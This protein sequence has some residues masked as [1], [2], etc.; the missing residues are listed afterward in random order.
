MTEIDNDHCRNEYNT[1]DI[2]SVKRKNRINNRNK[3]DCD[4]SL[5]NNNNCSDDK[6]IN[7]ND[8]NSDS[9]TQNSSIDEDTVYEINELDRNKHKLIVLADVEICN[10]K[11]KSGAL[12]ENSKNCDKNDTSSIDDTDSSASVSASD[13]VYVE[14]S[15]DTVNFQPKPIL[16]NGTSSA[17]ASSAAPKSSSTTK[18]SVSFD[19]NDDSVKKF[20]SGDVIVDQENPFKRANALKRAEF[21]SY[22]TANGVPSFPKPL[23]PVDKEEFVSTEDVLKE[24]KFVRTYIKHPDEYFVYDP[25]LKQRLLQEEALERAAR[26]RES[27][28]SPPKKSSRISRLTHERLK[29]LK[30]KYSPPPL[31]GQNKIRNGNASKLLNGSVSGA[32]FRITK[33]NKKKL[34]DR[35]KYPELSQI[36]VKI[37]TDLEESLFNPKEVALNARKFDVRIKNTQFGSQDDLDEITDI[38]SAINGDALE[39]LELDESDGKVIEVRKLNCI[40]TTYNST[41]QPSDDKTTNS[42]TNT[43]NSKEFQEYLKGKG[44]S[45]LPEQ[46]S[47][48]NSNL[49]SNGYL[50]TP[51]RIIEPYDLSCVM[52]NKKPKKPSVLQRLFPSGIFSSR[53]KTTP[54]EITPEPRKLGNSSDASNVGTKRLVLQRPSGTISL[55]AGAVDRIVKPIISDDRS[56]SISSAL[57]NAE[58][59]DYS[60]YNSTPKPKPLERK[61]QYSEGK[62]TWRLAN[63][64]NIRCD[65]GI[66]YI[67]SSSNST[68]V[69]NENLGGQVKLK[70]V[71]KAR[72]HSGR[73][74]V[75]IVSLSERMDKIRLS[76]NSVTPQPRFRKEQPIAFENKSP[77]ARDGIVKPKV[78][79]PQIPISNLKSLPGRIIDGQEKSDSL[80]KISKKVMENGNVYGQVSSRSSS[81]ERGDVKRRNIPK[82]PERTTKSLNTRDVVD[83]GRQSG[84]PQRTTQNRNSVKTPDNLIDASGPKSTSTPIVEGAQPQFVVANNK[85]GGDFYF[86]EKTLNLSPIPCL[87]QTNNQKKVE[88]DAYSWAKLRELKE[89]TDRQLYARPLVVYTEQPYTQTV[90]SQNVYGRP[91]ENRHINIYEPLPLQNGAN[92]Q[93]LYAK[94]EKKIPVLQKNQTNLIRNSP[95]RQSLDSSKLQQRFTN[96]QTNYQQPSP[97]H[98]Q[99]LFIRN[100]PQRNTVNGPFRGIDQNGLNPQYVQSQQT[101]PVRIPI[102][103]NLLIQQQPPRC[104]SVLDEMITGNTYG[105]ANSRSHQYPPNVVRR[106]KPS[107]PLTREEIMNQ[108][109]EFC[110][111]S[112]NKTPTKHFQNSTDQ[113]TVIHKDIVSKSSSEISPISYASMDSKT[114]PSIASSRSSAKIAPQ[115]P[116]RIQS[117]RPQQRSSETPIYEAILKRNSMQSCNSDVF[118]SPTIMN[119]HVTF[120]RRNLH[121][122]ASSETDSAIVSDENTPNTC[123]YQVPRNFIVMSSEQVT[124]THVL[125]Y[126]MPA[127]QVSNKQSEPIYAIRQPMQH[128]RGRQ[129]TPVYAQ[130]NGTYAYVRLPNGNNGT[131]MG[132]SQIYYP[133]HVM[134]KSQV[135]PTHRVHVTADGRSTPLILHAMPSPRVSSTSSNSA[136][137]QNPSQLNQQPIKT[138]LT[139]NFDSNN[140]GR[141][142]VLDNVEQ[143]YRPIIINNNTNNNSSNNE[144]NQNHQHPQQTAN[145]KQINYV[146]SGNQIVPYEC[147]STSDAE[148]LQNILY[149]GKRQHNQNM[150][151]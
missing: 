7:V 71:P 42:F 18:K 36:K 94:V 80:K 21:F 134:A 109:T 61:H 72:Q 147:E 51:L 48:K 29:E 149:N 133:N 66:R 79:R 122:R 124:P 98:Q 41:P 56:S 54:K 14:L 2:D 52:E 144:T 131:P 143:L 136:V 115:V 19:T 45:L 127:I 65:S 27:R 151:E 74:S 100:S 34:L 112:M 11:N 9:T 101:T 96:A 44:L 63:D 15:P 58:N 121:P 33:I 128:S 77:E 92:P 57:T 59:E 8:S 106:R 78:Y 69:A 139:T 90:Q 67:D 5:N 140:T 62:N 135:L 40:A 60:A 89:K 125:K 64:D 105:T 132:S 118:D 12:I 102:S 75:P 120:D 117:L 110:R 16:S 31:Y 148:E 26:L 107:E 32:D 68:I 84:I 104:Q 145:I 17:L 87:D 141:I 25:S 91:V 28:L 39:A 130:P 23:T 142:V 76:S 4:N 47:I 116:Q 43:V 129:L 111:K 126:S 53:R 86:H 82:A 97:V 1:D 35:S 10:N 55:S 95:Q 24:S 50:D 108:V 22:T 113:I 49:K 137:H 88:L 6:R 20:I 13:K 37:G 81:A 83:Q 3:L 85:A 46:K 38:T 70:P 99:Q 114:S 138:P 73:S 123:H 150:G 103:N 146:K 30:N 119:K 93:Q